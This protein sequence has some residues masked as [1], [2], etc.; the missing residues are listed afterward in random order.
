MSLL[1]LIDTAFET[2]RVGLATREGVLYALTNERQKEHAS[3]LQ[4]AI[5]RVLQAS[6]KRM[7]E[8]GGIVITGGPGSY[9][10]LRVGL[11]GAKGICYA[12]GIPLMMVNTLELMAKSAI[13]QKPGYDLYCP[14][15]DA[16]RMEVYTSIYNKEGIEVQ[17][18]A[19]LILEPHS[20][21][22]SRLSGKVL[23]F[24]NG[25]LKWQELVDDAGSAAF[26]A[27]GYEVSDLGEMGWKAY[28]AH[29]FADLAYA[30]PFYIKEFHSTTPGTLI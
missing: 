25:A 13:R 2:A 8:L 19:A 7:H 11:A 4:P 17:A 23:F 9:T 29:D 5:L 6:N 3:F 10:G 27:V 26:E 24:G 1:L 14:M 16:R 21:R 22:D 12:L 18:G 15:I 30:E 28:D 20:F